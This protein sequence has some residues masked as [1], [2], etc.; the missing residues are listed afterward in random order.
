MV[1]SYPPGLM[2]I[3]SNTTGAL[4]NCSTIL[5]TIP[6]YT[7]ST[8]LWQRLCGSDTCAGIGQCPLTVGSADGRL[9]A[10]MTP[11]DQFRHSLQPG[12]E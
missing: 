3:C 9:Q 4:S 11:A 7:C 12:A 1:A 8:H 5:T 6:P 2:T 10:T